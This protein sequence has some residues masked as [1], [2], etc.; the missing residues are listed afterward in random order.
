M[1]TRASIAAAV[2][3]GSRR[4]FRPGGTCAN[5]VQ[6]HVH[7]TASTRPCVRVRVLNSHAIHDA[8]RTA[9]GTWAVSDVVACNEQVPPGVGVDQ[10][11]RVFVEGREPPTN[12]LGVREPRVDYLPPSIDY[13][14]PDPLPAGGG[15]VVIHGSNLGG[16]ANA[17][18][19]SVATVKTR[20]EDGVETQV[21]CNVIEFAANHSLL[22]V[23]LPPSFGA[24]QLEVNVAGRLARSSVYTQ[25]SGLS[26]R[27]GGTEPVVALPS[28]TQAGGL[29]P[30]TPALLWTVESSG[31][32]ALGAN[33]RGSECNVD[34]IA[35]LSAQ[36]ARVIGTRTSTLAVD[37]DSG[38][39]EVRFRAVG[40]DAALGSTV[41]LVAACTLATGETITSAPT[42]VQ[43]LNLGVEW[44]RRIPD[45]KLNN[46]VLQE[47]VV[48]QVT[49]DDVGGGIDVTGAPLRVPI[50]GSN[51]KAVRCALS[52]KRTTASDLEA[53]PSV[54]T[55][56][57]A[58]TA[59]SDGTVSW[60][61]LQMRVGDLSE[62]M[63]VVSCSVAGDVKLPLLNATVRMQVMHL[64]WAELPGSDVVA[65]TAGA[66]APE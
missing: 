37:A 32:E 19:V 8:A 59:A 11:L 6:S 42:P 61:Q 13:V 27:F 25:T 58:L 12:L 53:A 17:A 54:G 23:T 36:D 30:V 35:A 26:L 10:P 31:R 3:P 28:S 20:V 43:V 2:C 38:V 4:A 48:V 46:Q 9:A 7:G 39:L 33:N 22:V 51:A 1:A 49:Q 64:R 56:T 47:A 63:A 50:T 45:F 5:R 41:Y 34:V 44:V 16:E 57:D 66:A 55:A 65:T 29:Q 24:V 62:V 15:S 14:T 52:L 40:V 18:R 60:R 21:P